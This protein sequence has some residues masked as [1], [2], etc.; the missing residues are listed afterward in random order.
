MPFFALTHQLTDSYVPVLLLLLVFGHNSKVLVLSIK[1][2]EVFVFGIR[3]F[4]Y[5]EAL[6]EVNN[7][8]RGRRGDRSTAGGGRGSR[9][10]AVPEFLLAVVVLQAARPEVAGSPEHEKPLVSVFLLS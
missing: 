1:G 6:V 10:Q 8:F 7:P 3:P 4:V 5:R 2:N 9:A